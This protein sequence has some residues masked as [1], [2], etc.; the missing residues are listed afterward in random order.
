VLGIQG[1]DDV[2]GTMSQ[3]DALGSDFL[4]KKGLQPNRILREQLLKIEHC[5]HSP[6]KDQ[7]ALVIDAVVKFSSPV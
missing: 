7:G 2:Y 1:H 4:R 3:L 6:H 5:G